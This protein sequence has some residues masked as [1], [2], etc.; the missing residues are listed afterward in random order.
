[1]AISRIQNKTDWLGWGITAASMLSDGIA[2]LLLDTYDMYRTMKNAKE[3]ARKEASYLKKVAQATVRSIRN[4]I[5]QSVNNT[6]SQIQGTLTKSQE[7][8][9]NLVYAKY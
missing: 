7:R 8:S 2:G 5:Y 6:F 4:S 3:D 1:M 9:K